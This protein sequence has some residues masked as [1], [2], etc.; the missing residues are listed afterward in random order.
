VAVTGNFAAGSLVALGILFCT[1][2]MSLLLPLLRRFLPERLRAPVAFSLA[3]GN[4][5]LYA[6]CASAYSP[7]IA[8]MAGIFI[9]LIAVNCVVLVVLRR[10]IRAEEGPRPWVIRS[11]LVFFASAI[12]I[13]FFREIVGAGRLTLPLPGGSP[14]ALIL[15]ASAPLP[16]LTSPA[17]GFILLGCLAFLYRFVQH[18]F[19]GR[20]MP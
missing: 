11:S 13:S 20:R 14:G 15:F 1:L 8:S 10:G 16:I 19:L 7:L 17:G 6:V 2:A 5:A 12:L 3:A 9:P 4:T 18:R